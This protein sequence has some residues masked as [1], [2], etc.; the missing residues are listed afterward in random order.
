[1]EDHHSPT[2]GIIPGVRGLG[3]PASF[4]EKFADGVTRQGYKLTYDLN[5]PDLDAVLVIAGSRHLNLLRRVKNRGVPIIQRLDGMNW[6]HRARWTGIK[7]CLRSE[8]NNWILKVIRNHIASRIIYQSRFSREWWER[9]YGPLDKPT[10]VIYNGIDLARYTPPRDISPISDGIRVLLVEGHLKN[11]LE[12]GLF[13][14]VNAMQE[15]RSH[16]GLP[17]LLS[18]AG[19]IPESI[20]RKVESRLPGRFQWLGILP[21]QGVMREM[22][23]S[24][25]F[26][27]VEMNPACPNS[28]IEALACGLPVLG[29]EN[30]AIRELV[31]EKSGALI[32][33]G[34]NVWKGE[35]ASTEGFL[36]KAN[37]L[38]D[39]L[40]EFR[41][42]ARRRAEECFSLDDML[43]KYLQV[44]LSR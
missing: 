6:I 25:I 40:A 16:L 28:I 15:W 43:A 19:D 9:K 29:W 14:A 18:A 23:R 22:Q 35:P 41:Q 39:H 42:G 38:V 44:I 36:E 7:H 4:H 3:G 26:L 21:R 8:V 17:I 13:N 12:Q 5:Q 31:D 33:Y 24:H 30:G 11:G 20:Q 27:S 10:A 1:M 32:P 37:S 2:I 34:G